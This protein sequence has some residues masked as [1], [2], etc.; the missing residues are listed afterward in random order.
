[1]ISGVDNELDFFVKESE[2]RYILELSDQL[3]CDLDNIS[4]IE[5]SPED[6]ECLT[7]LET[8]C[9]PFGTRKQTGYYVDKFKNFLKE[10]K[11]SDDLNGIPPRILN[12]YL[13]LFYSQLR[14]NT[15]DYYSPS[16]LVRRSIDI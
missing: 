8:E 16:T 2:N 4:S 15:G 3:R 13:R 7:Q 5:L 1:M 6:D 12:D 10:R 11:L 9:I 14:T